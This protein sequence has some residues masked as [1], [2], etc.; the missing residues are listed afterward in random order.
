MDGRTATLAAVAVAAVGLLTFAAM[1]GVGA[2]VALVVAGVALVIIGLVGWRERV[3]ATSASALAIESAPVG[4]E[5][6]ASMDAPPVEPT[7]VDLAA[8][9]SATSTIRPTGDGDVDHAHDEPLHTHRD[10]VR[11]LGDSHPGLRTDGSTIQVRLLH[12]RE[13]GAPHELPP[14]LRPHD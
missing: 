2:G 6:P 11:H 5:P 13:H 3:G 1:D 9:S 12:E 14:T 7:V 4:L 10:L 8:A